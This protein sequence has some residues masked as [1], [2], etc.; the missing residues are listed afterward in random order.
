MNKRL[1]FVISCIVVT[2]LF[3]CFGYVISRIIGTKEEKVSV[4]KNLGIA[5]MVY[6]ICLAALFFLSLVW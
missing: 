1:I 4:D 6:M 3:I 2:I 5:F